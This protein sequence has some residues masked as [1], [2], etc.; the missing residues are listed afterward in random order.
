MSKKLQ[1]FFIIAVLLYLLI[2]AI[3][4]IFQRS[5]LYLPPPIGPLTP[6][7]F[8]TPFSAV[9]IQNSAGESIDG[10]WIEQNKEA[11]TVLYLHGNGATLSMLAHV[12]RIFY[13]L[14]WNALIF[15]YRGYGKSSAAKLTEESVVADGLTAYG[16]LQDRGVKTEDMII[17]GHS[18]GSAVAAQVAFRT[19]P[20]CVVLEGS[21]PST[22]KMARAH[23]PWLLLAP[24]MI[25]DTFETA[26]AVQQHKYKL[27]V[28][29]A[30][31]DAVIP[32]HMGKEVFSAASDPKQ[33]L[34]IKGI[35][36]NDFPAVYKEYLSDIKR[37]CY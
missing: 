32:L 35:G 36:H 2:I 20:A 37:F 21:F 34:L 24:W 29:H 11:K 4:V 17:W 8:N 6:A 22:F 7:D 27:L 1:K 10:W 25:A 18:L 23:Y 33:F 5:L 12:S 14:G 26:Q 13:D 28:M 31:K 9:T 3:V 19:D 15:D 30:Q 16:W